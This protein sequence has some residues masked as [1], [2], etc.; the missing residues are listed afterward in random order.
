M[1]CPFVALA[2]GLDAGANIQSPHILTQRGSVLSRSTAVPASVPA[3]FWEY[4]LYVEN[5][6]AIGNPY[7]GIV[8][9]PTYNSAQLELV[10]MRKQQVTWWGWLGR[11]GRPEPMAFT[12]FNALGPIALLDDPAWS[13][14]WSSLGPGAAREVAARKRRLDAARPLEDALYRLFDESTWTACFEQDLFHNAGMNLYQAPWVAIAMTRLRA[15]EAEMRS[16]TP[17]SLSAANTDLQTFRTIAKHLEDAANDL[18]KRKPAAGAL[19]ADMTN[20]DAVGLLNGK[21]GSYVVRAGEGGSASVAGT[22]SFKFAESGFELGEAP[23]G[24]YG[25]IEPVAFASLDP[26]TVRYDPQFGGPERGGIVFLPRENLRSAYRGPA[27]ILLPLGT[28]PQEAETLAQAFRR[29]VRVANG[30]PVSEPPKAGS[31]PVEPDGPTKDLA[32]RLTDI[33]TRLETLGAMVFRTEEVG[34]RTPAALAA[35]I[36]RRDRLWRDS[37]LNQVLKPQLAGGA[38]FI[39][40]G[41]SV[42]MPSVTTHLGVP[43]TMIP[44][45]PPTWRVVRYSDRG[46]EATVIVRQASTAKLIKTG[47]VFTVSRLVEE[48]WTSP[49]RAPRLLQ[50]RLLGASEA[51]APVPSSAT[52]LAHRFFVMGSRYLDQNHLSEAERTLRRAVCMRPDWASAWNWLGV[53]VVRQ[54][55]VTDA[56]AL[57]EQSVNLNPKYVLGLTNL[58]DIR[59]VQGRLTDSLELA[60]RATGLAPN[61]AWAHVVYGHAYFANGDYPQSE[62]EYRESLRIEPANGATHADLAGALLRENKRAEATEEASHAIGLGERNH[63]VYKELAIP[64]G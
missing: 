45:D 39:L 31:G 15:F 27:G 44:L 8:E 30:V 55:R 48:T 50:M 57:C 22:M 13:N 43:M 52:A 25:G 41:V 53:A 40:N 64:K 14:A 62:R 36:A 6:P 38:T 60:K 59:R 5:T 7:W 51:E 32:D 17:I 16:S 21:F 35:A 56:A 23:T 37:E 28:L 3:S 18:S 29:L 1:L 58:A 2:V 54:G 20:T 33:A 63:W 9:A 10:R 24:W 46:S 11:V 34:A 26:I 42:P 61:D 12:A 19:T 47:R 4:R 49:N